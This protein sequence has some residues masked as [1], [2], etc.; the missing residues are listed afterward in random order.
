MADNKA[1]GTSETFSTC[2]RVKCGK[3]SATKRGL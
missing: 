1:R 2:C 3:R